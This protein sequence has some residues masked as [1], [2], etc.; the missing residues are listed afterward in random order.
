MN[1]GSP[2][3]LDKRRIADRIDDVVIDFHVWKF[4]GYCLIVRATLKDRRRAHKLTRRNSIRRR[5]VPSA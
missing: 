2:L 3:Q 5:N 4:A 1:F